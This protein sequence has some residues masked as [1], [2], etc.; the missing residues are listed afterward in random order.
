MNQGLDTSVTSGCEFQSVDK[1]KKI[2]QDRVESLQEDFRLFR[3]TC[4]ELGTSLYEIDQ[5]IS[6]NTTSKHPHQYWD[7]H[8]A[9]FELHSTETSMPELTEGGKFS[10]HGGWSTDRDRINLWL[11]HCL[12]SDESQ[13]QLHKSMLAEIPD[14]PS[15]WQRQ[16]LQHW[17][18]D[19]AAVGVD[20]QFS[21]SVGAVQYDLSSESDSSASREEAIVDELQSLFPMD[22]P[23]DSWD[24]G[25]LTAEDIWRL[26]Q[27]DENL[28]PL[29]TRR[30]IGENGRH[31]H[32]IPIY[33]SLKALVGYWDLA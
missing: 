22:D 16:V 15:I 5:L 17:Y 13:R 21:P 26:Y 1:E 10:V 7:Q 12:Q 19:E 20:F 31:T 14:D 30:W 18:V 2:L 3:K 28:L 29:G 27:A 23:N 4:I 24:L 6:R 25:I 32:E 8:N 33:K 9:P 11:L